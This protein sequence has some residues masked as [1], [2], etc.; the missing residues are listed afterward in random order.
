MLQ[1][2]SIDIEKKGKEVFSQDERNKLIRFFELLIQ[3]DYKAKK[4]IV[5]YEIS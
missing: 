1:K 2:K 4:R 3:I 5:R